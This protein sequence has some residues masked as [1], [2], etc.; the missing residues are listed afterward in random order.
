MARAT[1]PLG[2][3]CE[4]FFLDIFTFENM[5]EKKVTQQPQPVFCA[6]ASVCGSLPSASLALSET[7]YLPHSERLNELFS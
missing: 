2:L 5:H 4:H 6:A 3:S 1:L 7:R